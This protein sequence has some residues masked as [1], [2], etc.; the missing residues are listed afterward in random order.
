MEGL[1]AVAKG[2]D[3]STSPLT[4]EETSVARNA[5][6]VAIALNYRVDTSG[7]G[8]DTPN[9]ELSWVDFYR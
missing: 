7:L 3:G 1:D 5:D 4:I 8:T 2:A 6:G 9:I